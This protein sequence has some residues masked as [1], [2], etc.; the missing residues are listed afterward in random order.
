[1]ECEYSPQIRLGAI[2]IFGKRLRHPGKRDPKVSWSL[3]KDTQRLIGIISRSSV[4]DVKSLCDFIGSCGRGQTFK[5]RDKSV[6]DLLRGLLPGMYQAPGG[7]GIQDQRPLQRLY[8]KMLPACSSDFIAD[9]LDSRDEANPLFRW[10]D[11][12]RLARS[13]RALFIQRAHEHLFGGRRD[14]DIDRYLDILLKDTEFA[15]QTLYGRLENR[16]SDERWARSDEL[17]VLLPIL[18]GL[19]PNRHASWARKETRILAMIKLGFDLIAKDRDTHKFGREKLWTIAIQGWNRRP[20]IFEDVL[21]HGMRLKLAGMPD[22][23]PRGYLSVCNTAPEHLRPRLLQLYC[24]HVP[25]RGVDISTDEDFS[26]LQRQIWPRAVFSHVSTEQ[27]IRMLKRLSLVNLEY[28]FLQP[29]AD[30]SILNIQEVSATSQK[31]FNVDLLLTML[32]RSDPNVQKTAREAVENLR[33][34]AAISRSQRERIIFARAAVAYS[35]ATGDLGVYGGTIIWQQRFIRDPMTLKLLFVRETIST[36]EGLDL[37]SGLPPLNESE[38][39]IPYPIA[40]TIDRVRSNITKAD[41][42]LRTFY[43]TYRAAKREPSFNAGDWIETK[44]M[45]GSVYKR[46]VDRLECSQKLLGI[47]MSDLHTVVWDGFLSSIAW[48]D[49]EFLEVAQGPIMLLLGSLGPA[50]RL[51]ATKSLLDVGTEGRKRRNRTPKDELLDRMSYLALKMARGNASELSL[52]LLVQ[53]I[54][55]RPDASAWHRELLSVGFLKSLSAKKAHDVLASLARGIGEKLT[56]Q[57]YVNLSE[58]EASEHAPSQP[59]V[60]VTTVKYLAALLR[61]EEYISTESAVDILI[62]FFKQAQHRDIRLATL[63]SLLSLLAGICT[64]SQGS[65]RDSQRIDTILCALETA[66]PTAGSIN[67]GHPPRPQDWKDVT[68]TGVLPEI[69]DIPQQDM[70]PLMKTLLRAMCDGKYPGLKKIQSEYFKRIVVPILEQ[71]RLEHEKWIRLFLAKHN[72]P[73][74][75]D[76]VPLVPVAPHA[77]AF[78]MTSLY[79]LV[80]SKLFE[81]YIAWGKYRIAPDP[82]IAKFNAGLRA[83]VEL[84]KSPEVQ[85]WLQ[86]FDRQILKFRQSETFTL[87]QILNARGTVPTSM[88]YTPVVNAIVQHAGL[89]LDNYE[90]YVELWAG[91][92]TALAP[93][94]QVV[95]D[96]S[97]YARWIESHGSIVNQICDMVD[98]RRQQ[99][100]HTMLP[101]TIKL[102]LWLLFCPIPDGN[103]EEEDR[104]LVHRLV[105]FL[106][107]ELEH[108]DSQPLHWQEIASDVGTTLSLLLGTDESKSRTADEFGKLLGVKGATPEQRHARQALDLIKVDV[109]MRLFNDCQDKTKFAQIIEQRMGEWSACDSRAIRERASR[110]LSED[111]VMAL[112]ALRDS[113]DLQDSIFSWQPHLSRTSL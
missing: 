19:V 47:P 21:V 50:S 61:N 87:Q 40:L 78:T 36:N 106:L 17:R 63:D 109:A 103:D 5:E 11:L 71:S 81:G 32:H 2:K 37:L 41:D 82:T 85:H 58:P 60:K 3:L 25:D 86:V 89:Y 20:D 46:R 55:D 51:S 107:A 79:P 92:V 52:S 56:E 76:D 45:V 62:D 38:S 88:T 9:V 72:A 26:P 74:T 95:Q 13:H 34:K 39:L 54:L 10:R 42:V 65:P 35:I 44:A 90:K 30:V 93:T 64:E 33:K 18:C 101:S 31:N 102:Q 29:A 113:R 7:A 48:M 112:S 91:F 111:L 110:G 96:Y 99:E 69:C 70:A 49:F 53:T 43:E 23:V 14:Y 8:A 24:L 94:S 12:P 98:K 15:P 80:D 108:N 100:S 59:M 83:T 75:S 28:N 4:A 68:A 66:V 97:K 22:D 104:I 67:E 16:I 6:E 27:R 84:R 57:S 105:K 73:F 1:M 77:L